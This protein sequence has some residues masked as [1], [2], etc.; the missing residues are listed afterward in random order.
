M[1]AFASRHFRVETLAPGVHA[2]IATAGG[3]ALCNS[4][5]VDLGG[6]TLVFDT[7]LTPMAGAEL[8][9]AAERLTGRR[10]AWAVNSHWHGDHIWGN[11]EFASGH[12][13]SS[14]IARATIL[15]RSRAQWE[16]DRREMRRELPRIDARDSPYPPRDRELLRGWYSGVL[17]T[18]RSHRI[19]PPSVTFEDRLVI[20]GAR[21]AVHLVTYGGGHSPSDVFAFLPD[22]RVVFAGDLAMRGLHPSVGDGWP[23]TWV[24]ILRRMERLRPTTVLPGHGAPG[25]GRTLATNRGYLQELER[26]AERAVREHRS[27]RDLAQTPVPEKYRR[28]GFSFM[29]PGNL[30]RAYRLE[31]SGARKK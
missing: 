31:R 22:E 5:I 10:P 3:Y 16:G 4:A 21:R 27:A 15:E 13:A 18:P 29:F 28:W 8:A 20:E 12:I 25:G 6:E 2:A 14:R 23:R 19:V 26:T 30:L 1:P 7:M 17:A 11:S 9:R 24:S